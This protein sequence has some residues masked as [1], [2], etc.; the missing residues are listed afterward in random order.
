M[1]ILLKQLLKDIEKVGI[2]YDENININSIECN[3][4][5]VKKGSLFVCIKGYKSDGHDYIPDAIRKGAVAV[6][7]ES[8]QKNCNIPQIQVKN[9][10]HALAA[11]AAKFYENPSEAM[12]VIGITAT[13]G[14]TTTSFMINSIFE[15]NG[16][17]TGLIGTVKVKCGDTS[18]IAKLT[19]P[20]SL[21]LQHYFSRMRKNNVSHVAMEVSSAALAL[22]RV[23]EVDFDIVVLNNISREHID[24]HGSFQDYYNC[25]ASLIRNAKPN[26]WA[27]LNLDC[28]YSASLVTETKAKVITFGVEKNTGDFCCSKLD[29]SSGRAKFT[30]ECRKAINGLEYIPKKFDIELSIPGYHSVYNSMAAIIVAL[31]CKVPISIIQES[32][33]NFKGVE[34]RF[35]FIYEDG[36]KI[37]DD[38]FAN[39]GNIDVTLQTLKYMNYK[40]LHLVYAIRGNRGLTVN[41]ENALTIAKWAK[42]L[43]LKE[44][45]ATLSRSHVLEKDTVQIEEA[46]IFK[47]VMSSAGINVHLYEQLPDAIE[48]GLS[49]TRNDDVLLLAGCQGMDYGAEIAL[50]RI[51]Q[52][53]PN[54]S[55]DKL[56]NVIK[57]REIFTKELIS[58]YKLNLREEKYE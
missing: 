15:R 44:V 25:K 26:Q 11:L 50:D 51:S 4:K 20:E 18:E 33:K 52:L 9:S 53:E 34:R 37:I 5:N 12:K 46:E 31:I 3:S 49:K 47:K 2:A 10:R 40:K 24:F 14:K 13:N 16:Y 35:E 27:I 32:L 30:V 1:A 29:L 7:V 23:D 38:H 41:K 57:Y 17:K 19:T 8:F 28:P 43:G 54:L 36:F 58:R 42:V 45:T 22:N 6:V 21:D 39:S 48:Y 56:F 55:K